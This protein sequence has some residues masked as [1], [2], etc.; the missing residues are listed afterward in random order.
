MHD[1]DENDASLLRRFAR[2]RA[3]DAFAE[4]VRRHLGLVYAAALRQVGGDA[5]L[6]QD[7]AQ[8]VFTDLA[9]KASALAGRDTLAGWLHTSTHHAAAN[10]VRAERRRHKREEEAHAM[11]ELSNDAPSDNAWAQVRPVLD[12]T[13]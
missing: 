11:Q 12:D 7:V 10:A 1:A 4:L 5:H 6:A 9:R 13:L 3:D 8:L 2:D